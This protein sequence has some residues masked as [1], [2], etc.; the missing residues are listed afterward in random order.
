MQSGFGW[1][2]ASDEEQGVR[3]TPLHSMRD[4]VGGHGG[5]ELVV[6]LG[7]RNGLFQIQ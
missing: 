3:F 6:R 2:G 7:D 4:A 1:C 5:D